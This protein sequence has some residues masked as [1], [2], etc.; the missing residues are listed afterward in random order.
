MLARSPSR[1]R[2]GAT[3]LARTKAALE[4]VGSARALGAALRERGLRR[5]AAEVID[6]AFTD[7]DRLPETKHAGCP[8]NHGPRCTGSRTPG[9]RSG[10]DG[11]PRGRR[12]RR[13]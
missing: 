3:E 4:V 7:P 13:R 10:K 8:G 5:E 1:S 6:A 9:R 11:E 12:T 2:S